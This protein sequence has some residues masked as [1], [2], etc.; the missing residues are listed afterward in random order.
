MR[1]VSPKLAATNHNSNYS[2]FSKLIALTLIV[3]LQTGLLSG[4]SK[5]SETVIAFNSNSSPN[6]F[7]KRY[8][9]SP[10]DHTYIVSELSF[11]TVSDE[12]ATCL[13]EDKLVVVSNRKITSRSGSSTVLDQSEYK[14]LG[15]SK[16]KN[17]WQNPH[18]LAGVFT[19]KTNHGG[20][21]FNKTQTQVFYTKTEAGSTNYQL[22]VATQNPKNPAQWFAPKRLALAPKEYSVEN[23]WLSSNS[24]T[25]Y[26]S[27][28]MPGG[29]GG[30]DLYSVEIS[31]TGKFTRPKNLGKNINT[32]ANEKFPSL[33]VENHILYFVSDRPGAYGGY[34]VYSA[35]TDA[36]LYSSAQPLVSAINS[37]A[38]E[39]GFVPV[40]ATT[41]YFSSNKNSLSKK[42]NV[43]QYE[44]TASVAGF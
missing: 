1:P 28:N 34:D 44:H 37:T 21:T 12:Y 25:L 8:T 11:N 43:Y 15:F 5:K 14:L 41:G 2:S 39:V 42:M 40:T 22:Y 24:K 35:Y 9:S 23:P 10:D 17:N 13:F 33:S 20:L 3:A 36:E 6:L 27:S 19:G 32:S 30:Y 38:D 4:Q 29:Y 16:F 31:P 26:F 7:A 18:L